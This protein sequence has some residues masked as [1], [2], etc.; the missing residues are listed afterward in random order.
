ML[1]IGEV[2]IQPLLKILVVLQIEGLEVQD[3]C[4]KFLN[5]CNVVATE[6]VPLV[7]VVDRLDVGGRPFKFIKEGKVVYTVFPFDKPNNR[8][9]ASA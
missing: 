2:L 6:V 3:T 8:M 4:F 1:Q 7:R 9:Y 5:S